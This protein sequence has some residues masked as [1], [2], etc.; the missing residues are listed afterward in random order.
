M[1]QIGVNRFFRHWFNWVSGACSWLSRLSFCHFVSRRKKFLLKVLCQGAAQDLQELIVLLLAHFSRLGFA[2]HLCG[3]TA[4]PDRRFAQL[5]AGFARGRVDSVAIRSSRR[6][7]TS[8]WRSI[9]TLI[10]S[11]ICSTMLVDENCSFRYTL[12][13]EFTMPHAGASMQ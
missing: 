5:H 13:C 3:L 4:Y 2:T 8:V 7:E 11:K 10:F 9:S 6:E 12:A 1:G